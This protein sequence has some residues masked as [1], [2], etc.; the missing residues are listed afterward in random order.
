MLVSLS[1]PAQE[2]DKS[3]P[4]RARATGSEGGWVAK[5]TRP[6]N[7]SACPELKPLPAGPAVTTGALWDPRQQSAV[8]PHNQ[9]RSPE[10]GDTSSPDTP[11]RC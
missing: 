1:P 10:H 8:S 2:V 4:F 7:F 11:L 3:A 5:G 6:R 9:P